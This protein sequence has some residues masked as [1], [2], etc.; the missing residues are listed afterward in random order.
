M[1]A[2]YC[3]KKQQLLAEIERVKSINEAVNQE[4]NTPIGIERLLQLKVL[5]DS[6]DKLQAKID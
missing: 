2:A 6:N 3:L 1:S 5:I 4:K